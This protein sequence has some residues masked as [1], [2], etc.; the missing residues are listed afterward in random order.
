MSALV[1]QGAVDGDSF[2]S[3]FNQ[4]SQPDT[5]AKILANLVD[6]TILE[7]FAFGNGGNEFFVLFSGRD[8]RRHCV[9]VR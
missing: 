4:D 2:S 8:A 5:R 3:L 6:P 7:D 9:S 1:P